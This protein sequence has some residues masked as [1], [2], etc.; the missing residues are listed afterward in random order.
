MHLELL[1]DLRREK[2]SVRP[3][4]WWQLMFARRS[5]CVRL[6]TQQSLWLASSLCD[7]PVKRGMKKLRPGEGDDIPRMTKSISGRAGA[8]SHIIWPGIGHRLMSYTLVWVKEDSIG[9]RNLY[10][11]SQYFLQTPFRQIRPNFRLYLGG[12]NAQDK[13]FHYKKKY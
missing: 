9:Y 6:C 12:E 3:Q 2:R 13:V 1:W 5:Q 8:S 4:Q 10:Q 7:S 11:L